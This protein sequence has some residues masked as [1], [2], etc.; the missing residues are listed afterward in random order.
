MERC[1]AELLPLTDHNDTPLGLILPPIDP[2]VKDEPEEE[3]AG[4]PPEMVV[5]DSEDDDMHDDYVPNQA[6]E[7]LISNPTQA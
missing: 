5:P 1:R 6:M 7:D 4:N 2:L 3:D